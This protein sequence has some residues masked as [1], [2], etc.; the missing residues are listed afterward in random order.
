[1][2]VRKARI[3]D[4]FV[5]SQI[6]VE[7][8]QNAYKEIIDASILNARKVDDKRISTWAKII[9]SPEHIVLVC[10]VDEEVIGYLSA[11]NARD[12]YSYKNE[13]FALY[14]KPVAQRQGAGSALIEA[15]KHNIKHQGFYLYALKKNQKAACFYKKNGGVVYD[16]YNRNLTIQDKT[17]EELCYVFDEK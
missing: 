10:E 12:N 4:A 14:V 11:G 3:E 2:K 8:W 16:K 6:N 13:I 5:I 15:Y 1:M 9:E 7:T 17:Y